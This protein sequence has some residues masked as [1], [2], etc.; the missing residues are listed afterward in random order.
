MPRPRRSDKSGM[1]WFL[2]FGAAV[3]LA[4]CNTQLQDYVGGAPLP[5]AEQDL[6]PSGAVSGDRLIPGVKLSAGAGRMV[7]PSMA[8]EV[9]LTPTRVRMASDALAAEVGLSQTEIR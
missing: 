3:L 1:R 2:L 6:P 5:S 7:A 9:T 8:A 4:G